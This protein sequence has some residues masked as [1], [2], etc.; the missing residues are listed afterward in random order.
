MIEI[1]GFWFEILLRTL[2]NTT[3]VLLCFFISY[4]AHILH[5]LSFYPGFRIF[6]NAFLYFAFAFTIDF[7]I[8]LINSEYLIYPGLTTYS[9]LLFIFY[10]LITAGGFNL[11]YSLVWKELEKSIP[12]LKS[13]IFSNKDILLAGDALIV[14]ILALLINEDILYLTM[15]VVLGYAIILSYNNY[16]RA[17]RKNK[18]PQLYFIS[19]VLAFIGYLLNYLVGFFPIIKIYVLLLTGAI[20]IIFTYGVIKSSKQIT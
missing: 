14:A 5:S 9:V 12:L 7:P 6:R 1:N 13:T 4:R 17:S 2:I 10:F 18:F 15:L 20:F 16:K 3:I 19:I 11:V 8:S